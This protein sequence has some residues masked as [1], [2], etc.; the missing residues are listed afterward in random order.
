VRYRERIE[1][2][3]NLS[4]E[5]KTAAHK[6]LD[7]MLAD[8]AAGRISDFRMVIRS[9]QRPTHSDK[10]KVSGRAKELREKGFYF[11]RYHPK[12]PKPSDV[13]HIPPRTVKAGACTSLLSPSNSPGYLSWPPALQ[14]VSF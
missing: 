1:S 6:A 2:S 13:W 9:Q 10:E 12:G 14:A 8:L 7:E 11:L 5:E 3:T 4:E